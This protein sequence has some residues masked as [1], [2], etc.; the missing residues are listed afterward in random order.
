MRFDDYH[1]TIVGY[2][3]TRLSVAL[4]IVSRKRG[5]KKSENQDDWL[6][7]GVYFWEHAPKQALWWAE[8]RQKRQK[9]NEP[10]A[11]VASMIR[12][13]FCLD[14]LDP[15]NAKYLVQ[16][17]DDFVA[18]QEAAGLKVPKNYNK[19]KTLDCA[20]LQYAYAVIE[21]DP[22]NQ[23]DSARAVYVPTGTSKRLWKRSWLSRD[24][25]IQ[26]CV[27]NPQCILGTWLHHPVNLESPYGDQE[28]NSPTTLDFEPEDTL[29]SKET[30]E[31]AHSGQDSTHGA[32]QTDDAEGG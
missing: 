6:G 21:D 10:I 29:G 12:L 22:A 5:Y 17:H 30:S 15:D 7:H 24:A 4:D 8:R 9:W 11:I 28:E 16:M 32:R 2:H 13:G 19:H 18:A 14:L 1:R 3:G 20:V 27:R 31:H 26:I 23:V 25:H